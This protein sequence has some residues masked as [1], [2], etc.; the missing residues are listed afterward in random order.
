M[1]PTDNITYHLQTGADIIHPPADKVTPTRVETPLNFLPT[2]LATVIT[3][4]SSQGQDM[5]V[6][7]FRGGKRYVPHHMVTT[8]DPLRLLVEEE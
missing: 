4:H 8:K 5:L 3:Y 2:G 7:D 1:V 6:H